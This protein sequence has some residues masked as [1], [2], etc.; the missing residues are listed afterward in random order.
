MRILICLFLLV[1]FYGQAQTTCGGGTSFQVLH[2]TKTSGFDHNTRN[3]SNTMFTEIG[4]LQNFTVIN[5]A[6]ESA[7]DDLATLLNYEV[8]IFSNTTGNIPF[9]AT[10]KMN[11]EN[12]VAAGGGVLGIHGATDMYRDASYP[13]YTQLMGGSR[14]NSPAHTANNF[15]GTMDKVGTHPSTDN[16]SDP[17][18]KPEEYYYWPDTGL[19]NTIVPVLEVRSTGS[20]SYDAARPASWYQEFPS[21]AR[22]FYTTLG[23]NRSNYTDAD[24]E[25]RQ[26]LADALCWL[27]EAAPTS[28]PVRISSTRVTTVAGVQQIHWELG[29][30]PASKVELYGGAMQSS[31]QLLATQVGPI[32]S[33]G[34]LTHLPEST[35]D[36]YYYRLRFLDEDGLPSWSE[37][38]AVELKEEEGARPQVQYGVEGARLVIPRGGPA[39]AIVYD[40]N[41]RIVASLQLSPGAN[42]LP[43]P[44]PGL[45]LIRFP[46]RPGQL[47][48]QAR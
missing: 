35:H 26:H 36:W 32:G 17:W 3:Q 42:M 25:F 38:M 21:G 46:F 8:I 22:S 5:S 43:A 28:L 20:N 6:D 18:N 47:K 10:Q 41:G 34:Y 12:F 39:Q 44:Q 2:F 40:L 37:W 19:V 14:R 7:F 24:N 11:L 33:S 15:N 48:Y 45:Y 16:L 27:V 30:K 13:F 4:A 29:D 31:A 1:P 9:T 23:H